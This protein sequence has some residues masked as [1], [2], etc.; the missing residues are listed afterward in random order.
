MYNCNDMYLYEILE[1]YKYAEDIS[2]K[3]AIFDAFCSALWS[4]GNN[5][6]RMTKTIRYRVRNDLIN[7]ETGKIFDAWSDVE[8]TYY[9]S[10]T[11][12]D[13]WCDII[14]QKINNIYSVYFDPEIVVDK[15]YMQLIKTPKRLY[16]EWISGID[17]DPEVLTGLIDDAIDSSVQLKKKLSMQKP[18]LSWDEYLNVITSFLRKCFE[19][20]RL[21]DEAAETEDSI[22]Q[23]EFLSEDHVYTA[24]ICRSLSGDIKRWLKQQLGLKEHRHYIRCHICKRLIEKKGSRTMYCPECRHARQLEWQRMSMMKKR[25][26]EVIENS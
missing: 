22:P 23:P 25:S 17:T 12:K 5:R 21:T 24:Y 1:D 4:C 9:R 2:E 16:Y 19:N 10:M 7:T 3:G 15:E 20:C 26:C 6:T 8:Y 13:N 11:D 18:R 14:R